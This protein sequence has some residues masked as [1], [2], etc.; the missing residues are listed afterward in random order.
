MH[1]ACGDEVL[2]TPPSALLSASATGG[3]LQVYAATLPLLKHSGLQLL[4]KTKAMMHLL[5][6]GASFVEAQ[7]YGTLRV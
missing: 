1:L 4:G 5:G 2:Q 7:W 6:R 3:L